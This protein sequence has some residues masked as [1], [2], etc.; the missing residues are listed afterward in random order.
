[1][2]GYYASGRVGLTV[3]FGTDPDGPGMSA[4]T[5]GDDDSGVL[6]GQFNIGAFGAVIGYGDLD[7]TGQGLLVSASGVIGV[8]LPTA[9]PHVANAFWVDVAAG[10]VVKQSAG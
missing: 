2:A 4:Y 8:N 9:D 10:R 1:V 3:T 6:T 7:T 5:F